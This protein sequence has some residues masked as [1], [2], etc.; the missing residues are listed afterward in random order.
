M[1]TSVCYHL[2]GEGS[3]PP[4]A[5]ALGHVG[6]GRGLVPAAVAIAARKMASHG[7]CQAKQI[8]VVVAPTTG[9]PRWDECEGE[10]EPVGR[11]RVGAA[12][13]V[14]EVAQHE[15]GDIEAPAAHSLEM[16]WTHKAAGTVA[17][18]RRTLSGFRAA[19]GEAA[20]AAHSLPKDVTYRSCRFFGFSAQNP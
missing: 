12:Q 6:S 4:A 8:V 17:H 2:T 16:D 20:G 3:L 18:H 13:G 15:A 11:S 9:S 19:A 5:P 1:G 10:E 14:V 7:R